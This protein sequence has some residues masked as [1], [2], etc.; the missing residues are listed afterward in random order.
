MAFF[1]SLRMALILNRSSKGRGEFLVRWT[2]SFGRLLLNYSKQLLDGDFIVLRHFGQRI[3]RIVDF[4]AF[5][6]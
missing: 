4:D 2:H 6:L 1:Q 5:F 3:G